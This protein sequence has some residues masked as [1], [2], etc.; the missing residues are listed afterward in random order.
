MLSWIGNIDPD[1]FYYAQHHSEGGF[2]FHGY[3]ND[4]VDQLL[5]AARVETEQDARKELYDEAAK[6]IVD[7]ASYIYLYNPDN[8]NAWRD[9]VTGYFT[10]GDNAVRFEE[11]SLR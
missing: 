5:D 1:G 8:I 2:N 7:E 3:A 11:T 9:E 4:E 10:R 6:M